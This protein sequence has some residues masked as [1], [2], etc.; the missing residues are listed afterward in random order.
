[1]KLQVFFPYLLSLAAVIAACWPA[2]R[3]AKTF[4]FHFLASYFGF[5]VFIN[6]FA[7]LNLMLGELSMDLLK[8]IS[9]QNMRPVYILFGMIGFPLL[10]VAYYFLCDF[11]AGI[12]D[13]ELSRLFRGAYAALW[14]VL[15]A[16]FL[17]RIQFA[18]QNRYFPWANA[19]N[20]GSGLII[21]LMPIAAWAYLALRAARSPQA[22]EKKGLLSFAA[23]SLACYFLF[24]LTL[25]VLPSLVFSD[26]AVPV[27]LFVANIVPVLVLKRFLA[28]YYRPLLPDV[29][30]GSAA[31]QFCLQHQLSNREGDIL[32]LLLKGKSHKEIERDLFISPHT[33]RNH[34]HNIYQKLDVSSRLQLMN[35]VR[36]WLN[37]KNS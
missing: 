19:L 13:R 29:F 1:M 21:T 35:L 6:V 2:H 5:L 37:E 7:F 15:M 20:M 11:V 28:K 10:A 17:I 23:F 8:S 25:S 24:F 22:L 12:L 34:A 16:L 27:G 32:D 36:S 33:I 31:E 26:L 30:G 14:I 9:P 18:V 4:R 3:L